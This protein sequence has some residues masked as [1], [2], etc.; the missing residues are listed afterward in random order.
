MYKVI[1]LKS[2]PSSCWFLSRVKN[3]LHDVPGRKLSPGNP[4][5]IGDI[6]RLH[7]NNQAS[8]LSI[9]SK[10]FQAELLED[11]FYSP[12]MLNSYHGSS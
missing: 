10:L 8:M 11:P 12:L 2:L 3:S 1:L 9:W 7:K 4:L 5:T 6:L